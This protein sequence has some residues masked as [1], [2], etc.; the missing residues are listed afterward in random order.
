[1]SLLGGADDSVKMSTSPTLL[2]DTRSAVHSTP[3]AEVTTMTTTTTTT[4]TTITATSAARSTTTAAATIAV[5]TDATAEPTTV[6]LEG[7][8]SRDDWN[9][10]DEEEISVVGGVEDVTAELSAPVAVAAGL[11]HAEW[12]LLAVAGAGVTVFLLLALVLAY[13]RTGGGSPSLH[14]VVHHDDAECPPLLDYAPR[15]LD[16]AKYLGEL[17]KFG[18]LRVARNGAAWSSSRVRLGQRSRVDRDHT[19]NDFLTIRNARSKPRDLP[20]RVP[21]N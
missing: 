11:G 16:F 19:L 15:Q 5:V 6:I 12:Q 7:I 14:K 21:T 2:L 1:V 9:G 4:T 10:P 20:A 8:A 13:R 3:A 17:D 18:L